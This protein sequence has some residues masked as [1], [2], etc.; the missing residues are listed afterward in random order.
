[1]AFFIIGIATVRFRLYLDNID[2]CTLTGSV[3][4]YVPV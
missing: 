2:M 4:F 3:G 1:M